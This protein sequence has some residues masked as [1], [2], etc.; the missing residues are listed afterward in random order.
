M[1]YLG[2]CFVIRTA[3]AEKLGGLRRRLRARAKSMT[4]RLR[5]VEQ[6]DRIVHLPEV[7]FHR[8]DELPLRQLIRSRDC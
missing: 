6:T 8:R 3:L 5:A 2:E 4:S 7:L 1:N